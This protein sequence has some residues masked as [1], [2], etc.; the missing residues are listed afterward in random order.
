MD[1]E[2]LDTWN[3]DY[4]RRVGTT[5]GVGKGILVDGGQQRLTILLLLLL[6]LLNTGGKKVKKTTSGGALVSQHKILNER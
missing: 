2:A 5:L 4:H 3:S 6:L 1:N